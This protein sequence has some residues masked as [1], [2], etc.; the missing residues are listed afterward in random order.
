MSIAVEPRRARRVSVSIPPEAPAPPGF[1]V[2]VEFVTPELARR[3]LDER[4]PNRNPSR[5][6]V[7]GLVRDMVAGN[8]QAWNG[9]TVLFDEDGQL[10][11]AQHRLQAIS[12]ADI[13]QWMIL[14]RGVTK[15]A[16]QTVD[17]GRPRS[18]SDRLKALGK[19]SYRIL[20]GVANR[21]WAYEITGIPDPKAKG[22]RKP[23]TDESFACLARH[24][25][26]LDSLVVRGHTMLEPGQSVTL[27]YLFAQSPLGDED[28]VEEATYF[29]DRLEDG[30]GLE[31]GS[32]ILT[33]RNR[34]ISERQRPGGKRLE[35]M[36][37]LAFTIRA[38][39]GWRRGEELT[40]L[41][42]RPGG[43][44]PDA[45]PV[46]EGCTVPRR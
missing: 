10:T 38:Y 20:G 14:I 44:R 13:G 31:E 25:K 36:V 4:A 3:W 5:E 17:S 21:L 46:I 8:F 2:S 22:W 41:L 28:P 29:F 27:H 1:S 6:R 12:E 42:W 45:F 19:P 35:S 9:A 11:D 18:F 7:A 15:E 30:A 40:R 37:A 33:L 43:S 34:L 16:A 26:V 23:T 32:P 39:N 24:P